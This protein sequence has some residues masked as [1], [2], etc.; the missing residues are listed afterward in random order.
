MRRL[1]AALALALAPATAG[2]EILLSPGFSAESYVGGD[3]FDV[4]GT[5][6]ASGLPSMSTLAVDDAGM[7][8]L[9][10]TGRRY[11]GGAAD[12]LWPLY[13]VAPGGAH[14]TPGNEARYLYGPPLPNAAIGATRGGRELLVTTYDRDRKI[15]VLYELRDGHAELLAGGTP[16]PGVAPLLTQPEGAAVDGAGNIY[17]A[18]RARGVVLKLDSTGRV[19]DG[20]FL[21]VSRPRL[22][23]A[24]A[25]E[26]V[27]V[28]SDGDAEAPWQQGSGRILLV[29]PGGAARAVLRGPVAAAMA[30]SPSGTLYVADRRGARILTVEMDGRTTEFARFT[31]GDAPRGLAFAPITPETRR[32]GLAGA[33][34]VVVIRHGAFRSNEVVRVS[35]PFDAGR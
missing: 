10:R 23:G 20:R 13:R 15:G 30:V 3:G 33:L 24:G 19:L 25:G 22:V 4:G 14:L 9:A 29:E 18:D 21:V 16:P 26:G 8:Y 11:F 31:D 1:A 28:S 7:L 2:A 35:G 5:T 17:V 12:D 6:P 32:A 27:W 34:F